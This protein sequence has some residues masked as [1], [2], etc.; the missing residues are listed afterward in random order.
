MTIGRFLPGKK[1]FVEM[2]RDEMLIWDGDETDPV[3]FL[4]SPHAAIDTAIEML[5]HAAGADRGYA[6]LVPTAIAVE[7]ADPV[8]ED[9]AARIVIET[10]GIPLYITLS[11][12]DVAEIAAGMVKLSRDVG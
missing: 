2:R 5:G 9:V 12:Q 11:A 1:P 3:G 10:R 8:T 6:E 7:E 4:V